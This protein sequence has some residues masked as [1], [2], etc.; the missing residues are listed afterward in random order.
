MIEHLLTHILIGRRPRPNKETLRG[1]L[2]PKLVELLRPDPALRAEFIANS[3]LAN[4]K[5]LPLRRQLVR[6]ER[7][8]F[9]GSSAP[10]LKALLRMLL[11]RNA[12]THAGLPGYSRQEMQALLE[13]LLVATLVVWKAR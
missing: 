7:A 5:N 10:V 12:V 1:T 9:V 13:A 8:R 6:I 11:I 2:H 3:A 4:T